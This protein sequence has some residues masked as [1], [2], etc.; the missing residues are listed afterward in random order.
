MINTQFTLLS[1]GEVFFLGSELLV[2]FV[3]DEM[4]GIYLQIRAGHLKSKYNLHM[5]LGLLIN[6]TMS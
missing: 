1:L 6:C 3:M 5:K 2:F 4:G